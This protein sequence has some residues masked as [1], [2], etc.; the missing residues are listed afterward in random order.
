M[1]H[2]SVD[3][4]GG[5]FN[6]SA[7]STA[8]DVFSDPEFAAPGNSLLWGL[9]CLDETCREC[10][11]FIIMPRHPHT[12]RVHSHGCYEF[13]NVDVGFGPRDLTAHLSD[14]ESRLSALFRL[15]ADVEALLLSGG[16]KGSRHEQRVRG[17][18]AGCRRE[19]TDLDD[20]N[21]QEQ[22]YRGVH[23]SQAAAMRCRSCVCLACEAVSARE[24]T[25]SPGPK[26][27]SGRDYG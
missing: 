5:D 1:T 26:T 16:S 14:T 13:D 25:D 15:A 12:W 3:A 9:G 7:F 23:P 27:H 6:M 21:L 19:M 8:G 11:G 4:I 2:H 20:C 10:T 22:E 24:N 18:V 17:S